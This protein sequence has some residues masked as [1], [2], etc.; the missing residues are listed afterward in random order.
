MKPERFPTFRGFVLFCTLLA[1]SGVL[2]KILYA[3]GAPAQDAAPASV[4]VSVKM[5]DLADSGSDPGGKQYRAS[6]TKLVSAGNGAAVPAG[7]AAIVTLAQTPNGWAAQLS[8]L[9][10]AGQAVPVTSVS[11]NVTSTAQSAAASA[12]NTVGSVLG[13][14]GHRA[15]PPAA[16]TAVASGQR[17]IL[18]PGVTI[19]FVLAAPPSPAAT[20][21]TAPAPPP[22][23]EASA[24][25]TTR[26]PIPAPTASPSAAPTRSA[27]PAP[28]AASSPAGGSGNSSGGLTAMEICFSNPPPNPSDL[29]YRTQYLTA[30]FEVPVD[31]LGAVP[32]IEPAFSAY[33]KATYN[34]PSAGITC[35]PIW[36]ITDAQAAQKK[37]ASG[38]DTAKLKMVNTGWRYGQPP[39]A[40]GQSG[41]DPLA[42]GPGGLDLT[43]HRLTTYFC[44]LLAPGGTTM[45]APPGPA[46]QTAYISPI[47]QADW[48]SAAV[49]MA[50][51]V[52]IR[53]N[54]VHDLSLSDLSPRCTAQ[55]PAFQAMMHPNAGVSK[56]ITHK[57]PVDW[58]YTP[59]Q[60]AAAHVA[61]AQAASATAST[62]SS[63]GGPFISCSTSGGAGI[64]TYLTGVFQTT[65]P[66]RHMP[67]GANVVDQSVLDR[68][69]AYLTQKGYNFKPGSGSNCAVGRTEAE[70]EAA[71]HKRYYEG[72]GCS[73]CGKTVETGWKDTQ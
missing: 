26:S 9:T 20:A 67:N 12:A 33:L 41:F 55:S 18:P 6:V 27:I 54:Y 50:Y 10:I 62:A 70:A 14:F 21:D 47:F 4:S 31:S 63:A 7:S 46:N 65:H 57:V 48:D 71:K 36:T 49:S 37:I 60:G 66:V 53:D 17:V 39:L 42:S 61:A 29:N 68:F 45:V 43:Q 22:S 23:P 56:L 52:Y 16:V 32:A 5:I 40:S 19:T 3:A 24:A 2:V 72:G 44:T 34:Y 11:A 25:P 69:Y 59:A 58:T 13:G 38:R 64:D 51:D 73:T 30:V 8:S 28:T 15:T 1:A 35:Q